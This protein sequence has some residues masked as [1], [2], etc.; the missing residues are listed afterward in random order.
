[1]AE[2]KKRGLKNSNKWWRIKIWEVFRLR[3]ETLTEEKNNENII[4]TFVPFVYNYYIFEKLVH[5][6]IEKFKSSLLIASYT[7]FSRPVWLY[8]WTFMKLKTRLDRGRCYPS[9]RQK[10]KRPEAREGNPCIS[11]NTTYQGNYH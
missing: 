8:S 2:N 1:M 4:E 3:V 5:Y 10:K 7:P 11:R 6:I 9:T